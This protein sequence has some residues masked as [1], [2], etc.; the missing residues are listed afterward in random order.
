MNPRV[1]GA[2]RVQPQIL[3]PGVY[4]GRTGVLIQ[5][6]TM[7]WTGMC[8]ASSTKAVE[9]Q[10]VKG[11]PVAEAE[12]VLCFSNCKKQLSSRKKTGSRAEPA[13]H[14]VL[15][16]KSWLPHFETVRLSKLLCRYGPLPPGWISGSLLRSFCAEPARSP[17]VDVGFLRGFRFPPTVQKHTP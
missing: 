7:H 14:P 5:K 3:A 4:R 9:R 15:L 11:K 2:V 13:L 12:P 1:T 8:Y 16:D 6:G 17:R 10:A